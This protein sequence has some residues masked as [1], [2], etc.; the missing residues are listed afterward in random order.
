LF[1]LLKIKAFQRT[2]GTGCYFWLGLV[3]TLIAELK[4]LIRK[5]KENH[6]EG[7][8]YWCKI[9]VDILITPEAWNSGSLRSLLC[10]KQS[11]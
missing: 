2:F 11:V 3:V 10:P 7:K 9:K 5:Q 8:T 1:W 6:K 4:L